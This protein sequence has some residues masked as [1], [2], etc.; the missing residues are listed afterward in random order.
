LDIATPGCLLGNFAPPNRSNPEMIV[1]QNNPDM[2]RGVILPS[3]L[4][5]LVDFA[6]DKDLLLTIKLCFHLYARPKDLESLDVADFNSDTAGDPISYSIGRPAS[7]LFPARNSPIDSPHRE[8]LKSLLP[9]SGSVFR[10]PNP[11][12]RLRLLARN[13]QIDLP[14]RIGLRSCIAYARQAGLSAAEVCARA[15]LKSPTLGHCL[16][17]TFH[18][19]AGEYFGVD[20]NLPHSQLRPRYYGPTAPPQ[21][22]IGDEGMIWDE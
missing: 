15:G 12:G 4:Q 11:Y 7:P 21:Q 5:T 17:T 20:F 18:E 9:K 10:G 6:P 1:L 2:I 19:A 8:V 3:T 16:E 13:L 22:L 14:S